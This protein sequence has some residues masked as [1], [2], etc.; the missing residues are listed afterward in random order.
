MNCLHNNK[1]MVCSIVF[2]SI[3][4][5]AAMARPVVL[6]S[7][8]PTSSMD[9]MANAIAQG[10]KA[11]S[12]VDVRIL[13]I[14]KVTFSDVKNA[15][16]VI[17]GSPVYNANVAPQV[18]QFIN[19]WPLHDP[20]YKDKVGA[21]FVTAGEISAGEEATQMNLL[22]AMMIFNFIIVGGASQHQPFGASAIVNN[23]LIRGETPQ[24]TI[25]SKFLKQG[26]AL[27]QRVAEIVLRLYLTK[28]SSRK[29]TTLVF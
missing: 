5:Q 4:C 2:L 29:S 28:Y 24:R 20:S 23:S 25:N 1:I 26:E 9:V 13:P 21:A 6:I 14:E 15:S 10:V 3:L 18:Q 22:R 12:G 19:T 8:Y 11:V 16:G 17:L 27:G 7:Y